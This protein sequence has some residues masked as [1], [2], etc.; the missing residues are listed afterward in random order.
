[1]VDRGKSKG[2]EKKGVA[3]HPP[4]LAGRKYALQCV[5]GNY[6]GDQRRSAPSRSSKGG[7]FIPYAH[8]VL[9]VKSEE[10]C[11]NGSSSIMLP[12]AAGQ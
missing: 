6:S 3:D 1:V 11:G 8:Q 2:T 12:P 9:G 7:P 5:R 4:P 10:P